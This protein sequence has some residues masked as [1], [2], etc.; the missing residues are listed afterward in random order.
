MVVGHE[1]KRFLQPLA[2]RRY[3]LAL[4]SRDNGEA[5]PDVAMTIDQTVVD[6]LFAV[7]R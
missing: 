7:T 6:R 1:D 2:G 5:R 4:H 3:G